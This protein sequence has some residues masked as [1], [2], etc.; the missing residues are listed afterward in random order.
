MSNATNLNLNKL[1]RQ[2]NSID[3]SRNI[4]GIYKKPRK[5]TTR[6]VRTVKKAR[7]PLKLAKKTLIKN[8]SVKNYSKTKTESGV[9]T[10]LYITLLISIIFFILMLIYN[11]YMSFQDVTQQALNYQTTFNVENSIKN[12]PKGVII[13]QEGAPISIEKGGNMADNKYLDLYGG[14]DFMKRSTV[15]NNQYINSDYADYPS[16]YGNNNIN[17]SYSQSDNGVTKIYYENNMSPDRQQ[18]NKYINQQNDYIRTINNRVRQINTNRMFTPTYSR[19]KLVLSELRE[20]ERQL[21]N[22]VNSEVKNQPYLPDQ[23]GYY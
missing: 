2:L 3:L 9:W 5:V 15:M 19:D 18:L 11:L 8:S 14:N 23:K 7:P 6:T 12:S 13:D 10:F 20:Y 1:K 4:N 22:Q 16:R 21:A 17:G